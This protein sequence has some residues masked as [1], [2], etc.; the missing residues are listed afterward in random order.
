MASVQHSG[1]IFLFSKRPNTR[2]RLE[3][4]FSG[5]NKKPHHWLCLFK[6]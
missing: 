1:L 5:S 4:V 2:R 6:V 3:I